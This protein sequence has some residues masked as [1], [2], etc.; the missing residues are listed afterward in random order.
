MGADLISQKD[1]EYCKSYDIKRLELVPPNDQNDD[2]DVQ[3]DPEFLITKHRHQH[4]ERVVLH[5]VVHFEEQ[6][7]IDMKDSFQ[8]FS[9]K[10]QLSFGCD[11][12]QSVR[13]MFVVFCKLIISCD[14]LYGKT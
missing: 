5:A 9:G 10:V 14:C 6:L 1:C 4:V 13:L 12:D 11:Q 7:L 8:H 3:R 2:Q